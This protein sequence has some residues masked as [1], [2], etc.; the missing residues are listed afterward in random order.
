MTDA[1]FDI[2]PLP[3]TTFGA[4]IEYHGAGDAAAVAAAVEADP[5]PLLET[6]HAVD[7]LLLIRGM[8]R[9]ND[10][11]DL[12][13][14]L[15][16]PFGTEVEDYHQTLMPTNMIHPEVPEILIVS[17]V[18]PV[19]MQPPERP[20]PP[21]TPDGRLPVQFP[22]RRGWHTD[23]SYRRPPPDLSLFYAAEPAPPGQGQ[24]LYASGVAAYAALSPAM[25]E[26]L[27]GVDGLHVIP[28]VGRSE[29]AVR[30]GETP[31]PLAPHQRPQPQPL[32]RVHPVTGR[33]ALYLCEGGQMDWVEG[34]IVG[35][36]P[37][38]DGDGAELL[39][40]I[41]AHLTQPE[42]TYAHEWRRGDLVI[43]DNRSTLHSATW[44]D[45]A[46]HDRV[47]WRTTVHGNPGPEY[48]GEHKSWIPLSEAS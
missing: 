28:R 13:V 36:Q 21:R 40:E 27:E 11:P 1:A 2:H 33:P 48:A 29:K 31:Q 17:N 7:G 22:H 5:A 6:F 4:V 30:A 14:R 10:E 8:D 9:I 39:Y 24:T 26:R 44:F 19:N 42:F 47:M 35:M 20:D 15:S 45:A 16:R 41:M 43:Y 18:A 34:P 46:H 23:Q 37:G 32:V 25:K 12:L 3:D 38:P